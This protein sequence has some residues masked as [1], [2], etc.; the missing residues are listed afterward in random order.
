MNRSKMPE[1]QNRTLI[2]FFH[3]LSIMRLFCTILLVLLIGI[4]SV[5]AISFSPGSVPAVKTLAP[6]PQPTHFESLSKPVTQVS[7][8]WVTVS[9]YSVP[10][11]AAVFVDGQGTAQG[12][13]PFN[14][15]L[16]PGTHTLLLTLD[17]YQDYTTTVHLQEG[18]ISDVNAE[19]Q[20]KFVASV[21]RNDL[22][23]VKVTGVQSGLQHAVPTGVSTIPQTYDSCLSGQQ[24]LTP[25][26]AEAV[27]APGWRCSEGPVCGVSN[28][29]PK[30]CCSGS[31]EQSAGPGTPGDLVT[32]T[33]A[34]TLRTVTRDLAG[35]LLP[36]TSTTPRALGGQRPVGVIDSLFGFFSGLFSK[37]TCSPGQ[38]VC[39]GKCVNLTKDSANCGGCDYTCFD[40]AFCYAGECTSMSMR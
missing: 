19:L 32:L 36:V 11:G 2:I 22:A 5:S 38:T 33:S 20:R 29:V 14:L 40:P 10:S 17:N 31:P 9:V 25:A 30:S 1:N 3:H 23:A 12:T 21:N 6:T 18:S 15:G 26:E 24:C 27:F 37:E 13:T 8:V 35:N 4:A 16:H 34:P 7:D 28:S 39:S